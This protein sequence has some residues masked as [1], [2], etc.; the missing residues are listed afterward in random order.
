MVL[1]PDCPVIIFQTY[2]LIL[3]H[4][5]NIRLQ[6][7]SKTFIALCLE[8]AKFLYVF[9]YSIQFALFITIFYD[10]F[11]MPKKC[12]EIASVS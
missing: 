6:S 2:H 10:L 4:S 5:Q 9:F 11:N 1:L 7:T 12:D 8:I 3:K